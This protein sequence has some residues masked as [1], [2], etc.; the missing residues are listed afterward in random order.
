V[1]LP[2]DTSRW[3][4][5]VFDATSHRLYIAHLGAN[6]I[7]VFDTRRQ[8]MAGVVDGISQVHGLVL[9][10]DLG[11][12]YAS[13]TGRNQ[14]AVIDTSRLAVIGTVPTGDYPDGL[15]Y[16]AE[17]GKVYVSKSCPRRCL[18]AGGLDI[19]PTC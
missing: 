6:Q 1:R 17:A 12:L 13:A 9:A 7:V 10:G 14:V 15:A 5:Q 8:Q 11:R 4:Y 19:D 2:G 16:V 3:D 18:T